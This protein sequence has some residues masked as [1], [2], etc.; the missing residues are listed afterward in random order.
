MNDANSIEGYCS[1]ATNVRII[2]RRHA[3]SQDWDEVGGGDWGVLMKG[4]ML[5]GGGCR[6]SAAVTI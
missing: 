4:V 5:V 2:C 1:F 3:F 6:K